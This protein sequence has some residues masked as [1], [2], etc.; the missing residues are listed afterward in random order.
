MACGV[1]SSTL[2]IPLW[3]MILLGLAGLALFLLGI[4]YGDKIEQA[5]L[6]KFKK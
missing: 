6:D 4:R 5:L 3:G 1:G 2:V